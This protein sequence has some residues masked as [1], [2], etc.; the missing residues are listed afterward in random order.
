MSNSSIVLSDGYFKVFLWPLAGFSLIFSAILVPDK[1]Q[2]NVFCLLSNLKLKKAPNSK[3]YRQKI[4]FNTN[5]GI[6]KQLQ[7]SKT[8][9]RYQH[10]VRCF[11]KP[12]RKLEDKNQS[13]WPKTHN[14][15]QYLIYP[16]QDRRHYLHN[17]IKNFIS[18]HD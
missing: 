9:G 7:I 8:F 2:K 5:K 11:Q 12:F 1:F 10:G 17:F 4:V 13:D 3:F 16:E 6:S 15:Y 14:S 18:T